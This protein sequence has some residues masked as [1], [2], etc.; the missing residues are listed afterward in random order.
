MRF[1]RLVVESF[2]AI[3]R[4]EVEFGPGLNVLYGPN[5][6]GK[7][8]L[9]S[10]IRAALLVPP[11]SSEASRFTP[12]YADASP[13][14]SLTFVDGAGHYWR[15]NKGF[16][17]LNSAELRYSKDGLTFALDCKARQV[18]EKLRSLLDWGIPSPGGKGAPKGLPRSFLSNV[19]LGTQ[20]DVDG[21]LAESLADD[22]ANSGRLRLTKALAT[23]AQDP[24]FK[25]VLD[26][27]QAEVDQCFSPTGLRKRGQ[28]SRFVHAANVVKQ[29]QSELMGLQQQLHDS[30]SVE[31]SVTL[32]RERHAHA[33]AEAE[34]AKG[35]LATMLQ[36]LERTRARHAAKA[37]LDEAQGALTKILVHA[38]GLKGLEDDVKRLESEARA[39]EE[40]VTRAQAGSSEAALRLRKAEEAHRLATG[41]DEARRR[42]LKRAQLAELAS[43]LRVSAQKTEAR[44][45]EIVA[46]VKAIENAHQARRGVASV[47]AELTTTNDELERLQAQAGQ[48]AT[49]VDLAR[50]LLAYG[51]WWV[52]SSAAVDAAKAGQDA[53][54][55]RTDADKKKLE[56]DK[57]EA[58]A[59]ATQKLLGGRQ[60]VLPT[61]DQMKALQRLERDLEMAEASLGGGFSVTVRA[62][63]QTRVSAVVDGKE[64]EG[65]KELPAES[66][67]EAERIVRLAVGKL[68][69]IEVT[70]GAREKRKAV[71]KLRARWQAEVQPVLE[72]ADSKSV[73]RMAEAHA[74]L[75]RDGQAAAA[76]LKGAEQLNTEAK[77]LL[78]QAAL[79]EEQARRLAPDEKDLV[80]RKAAIGP[81]DPT[82]LHEHFT[83]LGKSWEAQAEN[84]VETKGRRHASIK[85]QVAGLQQSAQLTQYRRSEAEKTTKELDAH[86]ES[87]LSALG[88]AAPQTLLTTVDKELKALS[89]QQEEIATQLKSVE[90]EGNTEVE[91]AAKAVQAASVAVRA[92][93]EALT[94][95]ASELDKA[96]GTFHARVGE[97]NA[98]QSQLDA[99]DRAGAENLVK[100]R[101]REFAALPA[102]PDVSPPDVEVS[103]KRLADAQGRLDLARQELHT[104]E[105]ALSKVGGAAVRE[106]ALRL[107]EALELARTREKEMEVDADAWKLLR[108]TLRSVENEEGAHLGRALA[109]PVTKKFAELTG[110]RYEGL[111]LNS[112][113]TTEGI[114]VPGATVTDEDVVSLLSVGTRDQ[115]ATLIRLTIAQQL[116]SAIVLDDH[117]VHA[118]PARLA[119]FRE[120]L[121]KTSLEAQVLVLTCR[122][123]DYLEDAELGDGMLATRDVAGGT[124]R[125]LDMERIVRRWEKPLP[126]PS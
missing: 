11:S 68:V 102:E 22:P 19:L 61:E 12:W 55:K 52:A 15:V 56:A 106:E 57:L 28:G 75:A 63:G 49:E 50:A 96:R 78:G 39:L 33:L 51:R 110:G 13:Q 25:K 48:A 83:R 79:L 17:D 95:S 23:L 29:L 45:A 41:E 111:R 1:T 3:Q 112:E 76:A 100:Q 5:D 7:S 87:L 105:G 124:I 101:S 123:E 121:L 89:K 6:L 64:V 98:S 62:R 59:R 18:E 58:Q 73:T 4:A 119:W 84:I 97:R 118:D 126:R 16:G 37:R 94:R 32:C 103:E 99:M 109:Q 77:N 120:V 81:I 82:I 92:A 54:A 38:K 20:T 27:A 67:L 113:L 31:S 70:A 114:D 46:A 115:L 14:V 69:D 40:K 43:G 122:P 91:R 2:Q 44:K 53:S 30:E 86:S 47:Q 104:S 34:E 26:A 90:A 42:E 8:T 93:E 36:R 66:V 9:A 85:E 125:A 71:E 24:I 116:K 35:A 88:S 107:E 108:D 74:A 80:A 72:R 21:I 65:G 117:L 10:A 60:A